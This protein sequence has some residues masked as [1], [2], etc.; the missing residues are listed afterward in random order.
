MGGCKSKEKSKWKSFKVN[1]I[2]KE[3]EQTRLQ[4]QELMGQQI[5]L[6]EAELA[7]MDKIRETSFFLSKH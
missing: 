1:L 7:K 2:K 4:N 5:K 6:K 3:R